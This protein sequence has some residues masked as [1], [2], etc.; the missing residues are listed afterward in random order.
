MRKREFSTWVS[1]MAATSYTT[2]KASRGYG[3][4]VVWN[5]PKLRKNSPEQVTLEMF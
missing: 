1:T 5:Y 4:N 2:W 3:T